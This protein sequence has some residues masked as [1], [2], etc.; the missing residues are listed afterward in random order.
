MCSLSQINI[1]NK[2]KL[3]RTERKILKT[4]YVKN[5]LIYK[6]FFKINIENFII[7]G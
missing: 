2:I 1:I 4:F 3:Q 6:K 7:N 5:L